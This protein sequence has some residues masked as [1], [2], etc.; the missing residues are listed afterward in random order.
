MFV[1]I[2]AAI[3]FLFL[4]LG[5]VAFVVCAAIPPLRRFALSAALWFAAWGPCCVALMVL[6]MM[7]IVVGGFALQAGH[8]DWTS[9]PQHVAAVLGWGVFTVAII[10]TSAVATG[11]AWLHQAL[12]H[13]LTFALFRLYV[14]AV[15]GGIGSV[16]GWL[17]CWWLLAKPSAPYGWWLCPFVMLFPIAIFGSEAYKHASALRGSAP[18][19][20][21]WITPEEF[22][23]PVNP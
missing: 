8:M 3:V 11:L 7:G 4:A 10:A 1:I 14:A 15:C 9:I 12:I 21:T 16:F 17:V 18:T 13:R 19:R 5:A 22:A 6:A 2:A 20:F 23:G